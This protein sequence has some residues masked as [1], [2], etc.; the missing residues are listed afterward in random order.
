MIDVMPGDAFSAPRT[1]LTGAPLTVA[2]PSWSPDSQWIAF[3]HGQHSRAYQD[4]GGG[5][6]VLRDAAIRMVGAD[7]ATAFDLER[8]NAGERRSY[9]P[10]FSPFDAEE[11]G[12]YFW[13]AFFSTRDYG[14]AQAGTR[15]TGRRQLWV[16]AIDATPT[17]GVDPSAAPYWL[18][19]QDRLQENMAAFWTEEACRADGLSCA[20]SGECCGGFCRDTGSGPVCVPEDVVEC[21]HVGESCRTDADCCEGEGASCIS[22]VCGTLG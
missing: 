11:G 22:N 14:N 6:H 13:L 2:R 1:I 19:Q 8:L 18:P 3:Q 17:G 4:L 16:A 21:S 15:G 9:Y 20:T 7:G 12:G 5:T 10:T